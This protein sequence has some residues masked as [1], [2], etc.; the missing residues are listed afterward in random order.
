MNA[1]ISNEMILENIAELLISVGHKF[2]ESFNQFFTNN[3]QLKLFYSLKPS[4][5][6]K[7]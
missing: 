3:F 6:D 2:Y 4:R 5:L 7:S 1:L